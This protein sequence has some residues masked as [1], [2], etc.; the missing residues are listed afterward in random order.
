[1]HLDDAGGR[2]SADEK[3]AADQPERRHARQ[4]PDGAKH[5]CRTRRTPCRAFFGGFAADQQEY[6]D[7]GNQNDD[8]EG[9]KPLPPGCRCDKQGEQGHQRELAAG[10]AGCR[11]AGCEADTAFEMLCD[12]RR[13]KGRGHGGESGAAD[14]AEQRDELPGFRHERARVNHA[15]S[16]PVDDRSDDRG[17]DG[18]GDQHDGAGRR[19]ELVGPAHIGFPEGHHEPH[20]V[21]RR[22]HDA[23]HQKEGGDDQPALAGRCVIRG[24]DC[25]LRQYSGLSC[26]VCSA[27]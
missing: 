27:P 5:G 15:R 3:T 12:G 8:P 10:A 4:C 26:G 25:V 14:E 18:H 21:A 6:H 2:K 19:Y 23:E 17:D 24:V 11:D 7:G 22:D 9:Q 20:A 16:E 1:M 13:Y